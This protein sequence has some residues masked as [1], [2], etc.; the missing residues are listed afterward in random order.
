MSRLTDAIIESTAASVKRLP[1]GN[2]LALYRTAAGGW[3]WR[4]KYRTA[5]GK[6]TM[7]SLGNWPAVSINK[8][9]AAA[10]DKRAAAAQASVEVPRLAKAKVSA[11]TFGSVGE[12]FLA[13]NPNLSPATRSKYRWL[14]DKLHKLHARPITRIEA[15]EL[16]PLFEEIQTGGPG[17]RGIEDGAHR[18]ARLASAIFD[19]AQRHGIYHNPAARRKGWLKPVVTAHHPAVVDPKEFGVLAGLVDT[20][21]TGTVANAV[22]LLMRT[23]VR[24]GELRGAQW[25]EFYDRDNPALARWEIPAARM[26]MKRAHVVPLSAG[27]L[28]VLEA[29][30]EIAAPT[31]SGLVF[32]NTRVPGTLLDH[33]AM[34]KYLA[35][36]GY[37]ARQHVPHGFRSSFATMATEAGK[38]RDLI[39]LCLAHAATDKVHDAYANR[40]ER[41][42]ARRELMN[43]W[44]EYIEALKA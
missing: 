1:D 32:P 7:A 8:A 33:S 20:W 4:L 14:F 9:R 5:G 21:S 13:F 43:W 19:H 29:Q 26:K 23:V 41:I 18:A 44:G 30:A 36:C 16:V 40:L 24:P 3:N 17:V 2:R 34:N 27:A 11:L 31:P 15:G 39:R 12:E 25:S 10:E 38:Q 6:D 35:A 37:D 42:D 22:R 28:A